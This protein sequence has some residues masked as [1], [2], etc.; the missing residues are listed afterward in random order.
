M[1]VGCQTRGGAW[2]GCGVGG[3]V[4]TSEAAPADHVD[5][6]VRIGRGAWDGR[7]GFPPDCSLA[8]GHA[9]VEGNRGGPGSLSGIRPVTRE[10]RSGVRLEAEISVTGVWMRIVSVGRRG[11]GVVVWAEEEEG[12]RRAEAKMEGRTGRW[13]SHGV[14]HRLRRR[15]KC[16]G[17][18]GGRIQPGR[19]D[20]E[21]GRFGGGGARREAKKMPGWHV[22]HRRWRG[23]GTGETV[24]MVETV[25]TPAPGPSVLSRSIC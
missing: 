19:K 20:D 15:R 14:G 6:A 22:V 17:A 18:S 3:A 5:G 9:R 25:E 16:V 13:C 10:Y 4:L 12:R 1:R 7:D 23:K 24:D 2:R 21:G 11:V 8:S